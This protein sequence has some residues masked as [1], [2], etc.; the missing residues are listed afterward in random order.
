LKAIAAAA[1]L[2][3]LVAACGTGDSTGTQLLSIEGS[4]QIV[5]DSWLEPYNLSVDE[6]TDVSATYSPGLW[7]NSTPL[8]ELDSSY[9]WFPSGDSSFYMLTNLD[10][11]SGTLVVN[12]YAI[13]YRFLDA[14]AE[15]VFAGII[16][17]PGLFVPMDH[18][19][20]GTKSVCILRRVGN[21]E[22]YEIFRL[23][24]GADSVWYYKTD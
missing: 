1:W 8:T 14:S 21:E 24:V 20:C 23:T 17:R 16:E 5:L 9:I 11:N 19:W 12:N 2:T 10:R 7:S 22:D 6:F 4:T 15:E 13:E 3:L 18:C